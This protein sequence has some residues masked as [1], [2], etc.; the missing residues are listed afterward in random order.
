MG[1]VGVGIVLAFAIG[2][3][4]LFAFLAP[5][6]RRRLGVFVFGRLGAWE[7]FL[8]ELRVWV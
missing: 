1:E 5:R 3:G 2:G 7:F 8:S 6:G 4:S